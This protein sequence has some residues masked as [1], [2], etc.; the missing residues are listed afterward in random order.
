MESNSQL[1]EK[2]LMKQP[3]MSR[4]RYNSTCPA[5]EKA[6]HKVCQAWALQSTQDLFFV[7]VKATWAMQVPLGSQDPGELQQEG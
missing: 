7:N 1:Y 6:A 3:W 2:E 4:S 5:R